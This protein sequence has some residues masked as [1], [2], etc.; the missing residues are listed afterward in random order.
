MKVAASV[1]DLRARA[2]VAADRFLVD[3]NVWLDLAYP[4]LANTTDKNILARI[5]AHSAFVKA[6]RE[7]SA[8][9]FWCGLAFAEI[10][11][12][13]EKTERALYCAMR[14]E[15][16][17]L[18]NFRHQKNS[19]LKTLGLVNLTWETIAS[20]G[21]GIDTQAVAADQV[22]EIRA[23]FAN[24]Q[25]DGYDLLLV[26]S[27]RTAKLSSIVTDDSDYLTVPGITVLT[28]NEF[29]LRE[30]ARAGRMIT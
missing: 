3:T 26:R 21:V 16:I 29:A 17:K 9:L 2:P 25:I 22:G 6:C 7:A 24:C 19:R 13:I 10:A 18:K 30:A 5:S 12:V 8:Q 20:L 4:A 15:D 23:D 27:M 11:H 1:V 28:A 14:G